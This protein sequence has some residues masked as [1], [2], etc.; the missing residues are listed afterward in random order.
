M[1][2]LLLGELAGA[3]GGGLL[4][5]IGDIG[6]GIGSFMDDPAQLVKGSALDFRDL[7]TDPENYMNKRI[8]EFEENQGRAPTQ[9]EFARMQEEMDAMRE[10]AMQTM[11]A[12][13][14]PMQMGGFINQNPNFLNTAQ[15]RLG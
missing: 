11:Q 1:F 6:E 4:D 3:V 2:S 14:I 15:Q 13:R 12:S 8:E 5:Q 10:Q 9:S 7:F